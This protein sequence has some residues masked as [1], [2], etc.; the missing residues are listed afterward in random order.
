V[1]RKGPALVIHGIDELKYNL[2]HLM[3]YEAQSIMRKA[4]GQVAGEIRDEIRD[5]LPENVKHYRTAIAVY[6][7]RLG[8]TGKYLVAADVVAKRT[9][10]RAFYIANIIEAGTKDRYT[11]T[12]AFRGKVKAQPFKKPVVDR[13]RPKVPS[14]FEQVLKQKIQEDWDR[15]KTGISVD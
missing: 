2:S 3:P 6:R 8:R 7:P 11:K 1:S 9:P 4:V 5:N 13:W 10:P 14:R 12:G 15:R